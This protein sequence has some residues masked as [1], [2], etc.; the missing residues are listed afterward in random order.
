M[1]VAITGSKGQLGAA[2]QKTLTHD[3]LM[4]IDLPEYDISDLAAITREMRAFRPEVI[5]HGAAITNVDG[6][7]ADPALAYRVNVLGTRNLAVAAQQCGA[8]MV[9]ISTDYVFDGMQD[10]PYW[11][12]DTPNPLSV[13]ART[14]WLGEQVTRDLL[15]RFYIAR[16][17]WLYNVGAR[18]F[19]ET[20]LRLAAERG[21]LRMGTDEIGSPTY[22]PDLAS[23]LDRLIRQ[24]AYGIYH[25]TNAGVCSRYDWA[26]AILQM[27]GREDVRLIPTQNYQRAARVPKHAELRN[28]CAAELGITLRPWREALA[29][30]FAERQH[31]QPG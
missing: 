7:E 2:L 17:A 13:Y 6:C 1:R 21:E 28:F 31:G 23:A 9:Y 30:Y 22:A 10:E 5:I 25:L 18:N 8:V 20:V 3:T 27:A 26:Q 4:L 16:T 11:E 12:Y 15:S 14:K 19:I 24:P 29:N